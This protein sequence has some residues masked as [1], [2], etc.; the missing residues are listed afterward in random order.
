MI[1]ENGVYNKSQKMTNSP[2]RQQREIINN[3]RKSR[4]RKEPYYEGQSSIERPDSMPSNSYFVDTTEDFNKYEVI[5]V[6]KKVFS[7]QPP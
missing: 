4:L 6:R 1:D 2:N 3:Y 5:H 7:K